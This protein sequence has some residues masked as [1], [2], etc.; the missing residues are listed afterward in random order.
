[1][2]TWQLFPKS[3]KPTLVVRNVVASFEHVEPQIDSSVH[4]YSSNEVL[5]L[6]RD[7]LERSGFRVEA[8]KSQAQKIG[9]P[10]LFGRNGKPEKTFDADAFNEDE[11][12]VLEIEAGRAVANNQ[13]L[14]DL[15]QACMMQDVD[16]LGIAVRNN[17]RGSNDFDTI[18]RFIDTLYASDRLAL[19]LRGVI[20]L[21]Y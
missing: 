6:L 10:V 18:C 14:K 13:F 19:P 8:G 5:S 7:G 11:K 12:F 2:I 9:V 17:Y 20:I 15:F 16:L 21:G 4:Q 1:M 3:F